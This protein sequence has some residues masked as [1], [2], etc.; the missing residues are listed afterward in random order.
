MTENVIENKP[1]AQNTQEKVDV[2]PAETNAEQIQPISQ[3]E[4]KQSESVE[5]P[6]WRAFR[7]ARKRDRAEREAAERRAAEK[8]AEATAL[9]AAMEAAFARTGPIPNQNYYGQEQGEESDEDRIKR[10]VAQEIAAREAAQ[11]RVQAQRELQE[12]PNRL[13][14]AYPDFNHVIAQENLDYLDYHYPEVSRPLQRLQD[15]F[16]KWSDIYHAVKK[17]VPNHGTAKKEASRADI[18][19]AKPKSISSPKITEPG[20]PAYN[21]REVEERRAANW[22]RMQRVM[23]GV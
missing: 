6:N 9:K 19:Q 8:E 17:F 22:E 18:N 13:V 10:L 14:Q 2:K 1:E 23:K 15:G 5:D 12:Y 4:S 3:E 16:D 20:Q 7:E 21:P 11:A